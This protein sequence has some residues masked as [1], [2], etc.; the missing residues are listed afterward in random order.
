MVIKP[1]RKH[2]F[3]GKKVI[4]TSRERKFHVNNKNSL[5]IYIIII[6]SWSK[7]LA[8]KQEQK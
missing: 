6:F 4:E 1:L 2:D 7:L 3:K 8:G 5:E